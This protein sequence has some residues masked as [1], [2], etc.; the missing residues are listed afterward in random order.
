M[1]SSEIVANLFFGLDYTF[2]SFIIGIVG[3]IF[4]LAIF[5]SMIYA[6]LKK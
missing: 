6:I 3:Y 4:F 5:L 1:I 2:G